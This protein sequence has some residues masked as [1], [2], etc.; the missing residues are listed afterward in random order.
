MFEKFK[1]KIGRHNTDIWWLMTLG[2]I[3]ASKEQLGAWERRVAVRGCSNCG[4][5]RTEW[6][7][8]ND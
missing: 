4:L 2:A 1:C 7:N 3:N 5:H 6:V 8:K